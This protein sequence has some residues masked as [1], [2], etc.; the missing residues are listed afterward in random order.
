MMNIIFKL[1][2]F[3]L[4]NIAISYIPAYFICYKL[5]YEDEFSSKVA[6]IALT[7]S[8]ILT[9]LLKDIDIKNFFKKQQDN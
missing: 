4:F 2:F 1:V 8:C 6:R 7:I 3:A 5:G 9:F